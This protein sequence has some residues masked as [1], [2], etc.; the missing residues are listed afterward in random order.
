MLPDLSLWLCQLG[1]RGQLHSLCLLL[2]CLLWFSDHVHR[3]FTRGV[4]LQRGL[5]RCWRRMPLWNNPRQHDLFTVW[6][7][8]CLLRRLAERLHGLQR[9]IRPLDQ[10]VRGDLSQWVVHQRSSL[11]VL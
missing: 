5:P 11:L 7:Q 1:H 6:P 2:C 10:H 4:A 3:L 8:L 9:W